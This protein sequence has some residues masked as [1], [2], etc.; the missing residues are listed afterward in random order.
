MR[1]NKLALMDTNEGQS[2]CSLEVNA[3]IYREIQHAFSLLPF[4]ILKYFCFQL[5]MLRPRDRAYGTNKTHD[6]TF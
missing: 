6:E 1:K 3:F 4:I 2:C 5:L